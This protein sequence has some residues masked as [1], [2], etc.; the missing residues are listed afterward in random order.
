[1]SGGAFF[2]TKSAAG[3]AEGVAVRRDKTSHLDDTEKGKRI[4]I[5]SIS[6]KIRVENRFL[7]CN[8]NLA[9]A[10]KIP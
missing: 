10:S 1:V 6:T 9:P 3:A 4:H 5:I 7:L 8:E 2:K